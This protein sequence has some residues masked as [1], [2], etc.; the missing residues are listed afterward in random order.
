MCALP[1]GWLSAARRLGEKLLACEIPANGLY[2]SQVYARALYGYCTLFLPLSRGAGVPTCPVS[3][4]FTAQCSLPA[5]Y[6]GRSIMGRAMRL[7][8]AQPYL[9]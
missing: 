5:T 9:L 7:G 8:T 3:M 1:Y 6:N 4:I 2:R